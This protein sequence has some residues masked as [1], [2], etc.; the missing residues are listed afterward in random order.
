MSLV[1]F[2][3]IELNFH[4]QTR[5]LRAVLVGLDRVVQVQG[6]RQLNEAFN[7]PRDLGPVLDTLPNI[8]QIHV[9]RVDRL[10]LRDRRL[11]LEWDFKIQLLKT[12]LTRLFPLSPECSSSPAHRP[13]S[14]NYTVARTLARLRSPRSPESR[15]RAGRGR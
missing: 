4:V 8:P 2:L 1:I 10:R 7:R 5:E 11:H 9:R 14:R 13:R 6:R 3:G 15:P 12:K